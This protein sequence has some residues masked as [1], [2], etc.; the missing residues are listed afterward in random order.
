M[1]R[2]LLPP[3]QRLV[4]Q[5]LVNDAE[6]VRLDFF[7][8]T[9]ESIRP[10]EV[11]NQRTVGQLSA[12]NL[13]A[14]GEIHLDDE[15]V[16]RFRRG[17]VQAFGTV[18]DNDPLYVAISQGARYQGMEH[19]LPLFHDALATLF[20]HCG[21]CLYA[22]DDQLEAAYQERISQVMDYYQA[23]KN[24]LQDDSLRRTGQRLIKPLPPT[25]LYILE[26]EWQTRLGA[27]LSDAPPL[28]RTN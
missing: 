21:A 20:D 7:G 5:R 11:E 4:V 9:L 1:G 27:V 18:M 8:D 23:R 24:A 3:P 26:D 25:E 13:T 10:F 22:H 19:W 17:Y 16:L 2:R 14:A 6:P 28:G 15:A 12:L